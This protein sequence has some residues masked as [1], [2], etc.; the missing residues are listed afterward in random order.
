VLW[1]VLQRPQRFPTGVST[2]WLGL[3][4]VMLVHAWVPVWNVFFSFNAVSW[5]ISTEVFFYV[6]FPLLIS[7]WEKSWW[8]KL[9]V[10]L[11]PSIAMIWLCAR[12]NIAP[13]AA[14]TNWSITTTGLVYIHPLARLFEF[15]LGMVTALLFRNHSVRIRAFAAH[16]AGTRWRAWFPTM[17][18]VVAVGVVLVNMYYAA[19][20]ALTLA[21]WAGPAAVEWAVQ[22]PVISV[23]FACLIFVIAAEAGMVS[24]ML[25]ARPAV[26][27]GE[28]SFSVYMLHQIMITWYQFNAPRFERYSAGLAYGLFWA[29][30]LV[31]AWLVWA[32]VERPLRDWIVGLWPARNHAKP[33][34]KIPGTD[35]G[36]W[37]RL[38]SPSAYAL[39]G[40]VFTLMA[41]LVP[42]T[43]S[44]HTHINRSDQLAVQAL[45]DRSVD[46][47]RSVMFG[48]DLELAGATMT[49]STGESMELTLGWR[50]RRDM[51]LKYRVGVHF[52]DDSGQILGQAD[53][54]QDVDH[55]RITAGAAWVDRVVIS[56][57][58][59]KGV[60]RIGLVVYELG[61]MTIPVSEAAG[62]HV[63]F[64][65][66]RLLLAVPTVA[67]QLE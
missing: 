49:R 25:R 46:D 50:A 39:G 57:E 66:M 37:D 12:F 30:L 8:W 15:T 58:Q 17:L 9:W 62:T 52:T 56:N 20:L 7:D 19:P 6:V 51:E 1:L 14:G 16:S 44:S 38:K 18:E 55:E 27:L 11:L 54:D 21:Q 31:A 40:G 32:G 61:K 28:I 34:D 41:L 4:N 23:A 24:R 60:T 13:P 64:N 65:G 33:I 67:A 3:L 42:V 35:R 22:G 26:L 63:D 45:R 53:F 59:L 10:A 43:I 29:I 2:W 47:G 48:D 5:S 36:I